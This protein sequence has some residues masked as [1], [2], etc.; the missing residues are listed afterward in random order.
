M[1][2]MQRSD[3]RKSDQESGGGTG[4]FFEFQSVHDR[5]FMMGNG[6]PSNLR[7]FKTCFFVVIFPKMDAIMS[8]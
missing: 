8:E 5:G 2:N 4:E 7:P 3:A 6:H 1:S